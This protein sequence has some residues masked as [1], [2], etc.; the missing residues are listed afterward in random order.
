MILSV[1]FWQ[2]HFRVISGE[3]LRSAVG[4]CGC[5]VSVIAII[6]EDKKKQEGIEGR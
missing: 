1:Q 2:S 3:G 5:I 4:S 6:Q